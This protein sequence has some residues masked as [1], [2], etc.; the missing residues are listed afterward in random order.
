MSHAPSTKRDA[1]AV[2]GALGKVIGLAS[3][4]SP[5]IRPT[6]AEQQ[7]VAVCDGHRLLG[8]FASVDGYWRAWREDGIPLGI[9]PTR[10]EARAAV[11]RAGRSPS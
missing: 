9:F 3:R 2:T 10:D 8:H 5:K 7:A 1:P 6:P 11:I 4:S